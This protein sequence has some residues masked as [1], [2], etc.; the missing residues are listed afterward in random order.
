MAFR[1][2]AVPV[3][4]H[5]G[6]LVPAGWYRSNALGQPHRKKVIVRDR[7]YHGS[8]LSAAALTGLPGNHTSFD[9]PAQR[10][11][12]TRC[13]H[14]WRE[15][16]PGEDEQAFSDRLIAE[17]E[18]MILAEGPET[19]AAFF[20]E[21]VQGAG[22]VIVPPSGYWEKI[23]TLLR[24]HDILLVVDEV[25][26]GF[27][28]TGTMFGST[29][30]GIAPDIMIVS[31]QLTSAYAPLAAV[32]INDRVFEPIAAE[33][34]RIGTLGHGFTS[35]GHPV[36]CAVALETIR[37]IEEEDLS[38]RSA[39][40]GERLLAGL[41]RYSDHPLVGEVR[42]TGLLAAIEFVTDKDRKTSHHG[43][44]HLAQTMGRLLLAEGVI[45]RALG[46]A[47]AFCPPMI[48]DEAQIDD[49]V[50]RVGAALENLEAAVESGGR[51][52]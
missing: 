31:K 34:D 2:S 14:F 19:I 33:S 48:I 42:G 50:A 9:V 21:P 20:A 1:A 22:G 23:Q 47:I 6:P 8:T 29:T 5:R 35:S 11:L 16:L 24:R 51:K 49:L 7:A 44:G 46:E 26:C 52:A 32:L 25:V 45:V 28:R 37:I 38:G 27:G 36:S 41:Q 30:F 39:A 13:P 43:A 40:M 18:A 12:R 4:C 3:R 10:I 15:G 17:L